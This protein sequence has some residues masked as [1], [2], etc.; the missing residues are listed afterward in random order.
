MS[1]NPT[2]REILEF[3][4]S[5]IRA[6]LD[7]TLTHDPGCPCECGAFAPHDGRIVAAL[8]R[9]LRAVTAELDALPVD[10][11]ASLSASLR[12]R[13]ASAWGTAS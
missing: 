4:E 12:S 6:E 7:S 10:E 8:S 5:T 13:I 1:K 2:R 9:E 11:G 3:L